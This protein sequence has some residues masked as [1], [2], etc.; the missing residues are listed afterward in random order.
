[1]SV[2]MSVLRLTMCLLMLLLYH[3]CLL[4]SDHVPI[5]VE[6]SYDLLPPVCTSHSIPP[7]FDWALAMSN[8]SLRNYQDVVLK[9]LSK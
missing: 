8:G 5:T 7:K 9:C 1:M 2:V 4:A 6:M 3:S